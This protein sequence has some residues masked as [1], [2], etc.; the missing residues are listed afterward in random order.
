MRVVERQ[1]RW[2]QEI[3]DA[4]AVLIWRER[5]AIV[6]VH[7]EADAGGREGGRR[8]NECVQVRSINHLNLAQTPTGI[9]FSMSKIRYA[10]YLD[11]RAYNALPDRILGGLLRIDRTGK[12]LKIHPLA[13]P[14]AVLG[15]TRNV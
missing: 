4:E 12:R 14:L 5:H 13:D 3:R 7:D 1:N 8:T 11:K 10:D 2:L 6:N 9:R 15:K